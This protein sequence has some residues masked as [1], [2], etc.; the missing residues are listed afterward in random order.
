M[1]IAVNQAGAPYLSRSCNQSVDEG[2]PL[3]QSAANG[4]RGESHP[5]IDWDDVVQ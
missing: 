3:L 5:F 2:K 4:E 1:L